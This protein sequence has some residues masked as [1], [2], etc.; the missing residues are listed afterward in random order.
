MTPLEHATRADECFRAGAIHRGNRHLRAALLAKK[1]PAQR[2]PIWDS[3]SRA[4]LVVSGVDVLPSP[5]S[6]LQRA[7]WPLVIGLCAVLGYCT[8]P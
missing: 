5:R 6:P 4:R 7:F 3:P 8:G 2:L 1:R